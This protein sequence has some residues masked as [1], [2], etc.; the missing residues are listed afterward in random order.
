MPHTLL[1]NRDC[2]AT[3]TRIGAEAGR[4][5]EAEPRRARR[6]MTD[7]NMLNYYEDDV[8]AHKDKGG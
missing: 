6:V 3:D 1:S 8:D 4:K 2:M 5:A 7:L